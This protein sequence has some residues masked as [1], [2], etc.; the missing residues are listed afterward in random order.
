MRKLPL[1]YTLSARKE[2]LSDTPYSDSPYYD[3]PYSFLEAVNSELIK[4]DEH[5]SIDSSI[6]LNYVEELISES[7]IA[8]TFVTFF[9]RREADYFIMNL[10]LWR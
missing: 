10:N 6:F 9:S 7:S 2:P 1:A 5:S 4:F 8:I 3:Y